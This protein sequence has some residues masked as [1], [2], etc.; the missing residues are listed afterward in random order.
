MR[1]ARNGGADPRFDWI[2]A[3]ECLIRITC[4]TGAKFQSKPERILALSDKAINCSSE[5]KRSA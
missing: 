4:K 1:R 3:K 2:E 5:K